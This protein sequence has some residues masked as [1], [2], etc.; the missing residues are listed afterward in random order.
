MLNWNDQVSSFNLCLREKTQNIRL[1][2]T[3]D[4]YGNVAHVL[5]FRHIWWENA[6]IEKNN[7]WNQKVFL[8]EHRNYNPTITNGGKGEHGRDNYYANHHRPTNRHHHEKEKER[9]RERVE[10]EFR[11]WIANSNR[12]QWLGKSIVEFAFN[13]MWKFH[14]GL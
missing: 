11:G 1:L 7:N 8:P 14:N 10:F 3:C 13:R 5:I 9:E 2:H 4:F 6:R 12:N